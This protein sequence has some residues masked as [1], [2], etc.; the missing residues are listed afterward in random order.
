M[1]CNI[2]SEPVIFEMIH[3]TEEKAEE[4]LFM[5]LFCAERQSPKFSFSEGV[6]P[7]GLTSLFMVLSGWLIPLY[8][9]TEIK[10]YLTLYTYPKEKDPLQSL[11]AIELLSPKNI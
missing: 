4:N 1:F 10:W 7:Y 8:L 2:L 6:G 5:H 11:Q 3:Q 9:G